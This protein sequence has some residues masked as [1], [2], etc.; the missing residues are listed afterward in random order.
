MERS[1]YDLLSI[2][3]VART[4]GQSARNLRRMIRDGEFP[5]GFPAPR[6][7][8]WQWA[9]VRDWVVR[10]KVMAEMQRQKADIPGQSGTSVPEGADAPGGTKKRG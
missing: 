7:L 10:R 4:I 9:T 5:E 3:E 2:D 1:D 6:S 8:K